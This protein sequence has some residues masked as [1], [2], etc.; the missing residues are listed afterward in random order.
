MGRPHK[1]PY[2]GSTETVSKG[3]RKTKT[4]G[5]RSIRRCQACRRKFTPRHQNPQLATGT[6][7]PGEPR[8]ATHP[9]PPEG[10]RQPVEPPPAATEPQP[11]APPAEPTRPDGASA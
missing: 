3:H 8:Q 11:Q 7:D 9:R 5:P 4:M 10:P 2:C 1:C 6:Q